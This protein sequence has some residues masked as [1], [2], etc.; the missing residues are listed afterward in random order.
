MEN[1][2]QEKL[3]A[4]GQQELPLVAAEASSSLS[5]TSSFTSQISK[6]GCLC[7]LLILVLSLV[8]IE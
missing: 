6:L 1:K 2:R 4:R 3:T 8:D 7:F 5:P